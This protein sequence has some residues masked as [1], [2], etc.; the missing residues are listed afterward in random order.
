M[1]LLLLLACTPVDPVERWQQCADPDCRL[2]ELDAALALDP[3]A[4]REGL[5]AEPDPLAQVAL[6]TELGSRD[7]SL[8]D[9]L[10]PRL[11][12]AAGRRCERLTQRPHLGQ[13][14]PPRS[15]AAGDEAAAQAARPG[16]GPAGDHL[17][18]PPRATVVPDPQARAAADVACA[19]D[20]A[21]L[22]ARARD[23]AARGQ[24]VEVEAACSL[25]PGPDG[26]QDECRFRAAERVVAR[27]GAAGLAQ[28]VDLCVSSR[29]AA[30]CLAH[31][32]G[33]VTP[34]SVPATQVDPAAVAEA[35]GVADRIR[36]AVAAEPAGAV[37]ASLMWSLWVAT[38]FEP[39]PGE[40]PAEVRGDL[41][42]H[43]PAE[44]APHVRFSA[45]MR[46]VVERPGLDL[47]ALALAV[48]QAL[49]RRG[50][51][52]SQAPRLPVVAPLSPVSLWPAD[53]PGEEVVPATWA[54]GTLRRPT[55]S[56]PQEDTVLAVLAALGLAP[57]AV[58]PGALLQILSDPD[59]PEL[60]RWAA[61]LG[62]GARAPLRLRD[63]PTRNP[64]APALLRARAAVAAER[65]PAAA[66]RG[67][68]AGGR[69]AAPVGRP[70]GPT[71]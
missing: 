53:L 8:L 66:E 23:A 44:A 32:V 29:Y 47:P 22:A 5:V 4:V 13:A 2:R 28:A 31:V 35:E 6:V 57:G 21:C 63:W 37:A 71:R 64:D 43:L 27:Q 46:L 9:G 1:I 15:G 30:D 11:S 16:G 25:L 70:P 26:S 51:A 12:P 49:M 69:V 65:R 60:H 33:L 52:A 40:R 34:A 39:V 20:Q 24:L 14:A 18:V 58:S 48:D 54:R 36:S 59:A 56:D 61:V 50:P 41:L 7:P 67:P 38:A 3:Q 19:R 17:L 10:C 68:G 55:S 42:D 62:L 45:A